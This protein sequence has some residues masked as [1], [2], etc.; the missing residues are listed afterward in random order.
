VP[1]AEQAGLIEPMSVWV[2][3]SVI[4]QLGEWEAAQMNLSGA[5]N[6]P[7]SLFDD[8]EFPDRVEHALLDAGVPPQRLIL[9]ITERAAIQNER[10]AIDVLTRLRLKGIGLSIDD[11]GVGHSSLVELYRMPFTE[12]KIDASFIKDL[13][14]SAQARTIV[15]SLA[16]MASQLGIETCAE[17]VES[18]VIEEELRRAGCDKAQGFLYGAAQTAADFRALYAAQSD[19]VSDGF[20]RLPLPAE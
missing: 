20:M 11:F 18:P 1:A 5:V 17:G 2:L 19:L 16:A 12:L 14:V 9:E 4:E 15:R 3:S 10:R 8:V 7:A 13:E 6:L